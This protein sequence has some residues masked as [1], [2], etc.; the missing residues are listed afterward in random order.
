MGFRALEIRQHGGL[1]V[2]G[3]R[4]P[5]SLPFGLIAFQKLP[6]I[7]SS[8]SDRVAPLIRSISDVQFKKG[9]VKAS[10]RRRRKSW[11]RRRCP[12]TSKRAPDGKRAAE[13]AILESGQGRLL[14]YWALSQDAA[15][16]SSKVDPRPSPRSLP[17]N[18]VLM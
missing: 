2:G 6:F 10:S 14:C 5:L 1:H 3:R 12:R 18:R 15:S 13:T 11:C 17:P 9:N 4:D 8:A 7:T 16:R